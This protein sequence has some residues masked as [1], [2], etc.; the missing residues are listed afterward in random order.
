MNIG[1]E[2]YRMDAVGKE[3][4]HPQLMLWSPNLEDM[5]F[6]SMEAFGDMVFE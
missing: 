2:A 1:R 3:K 4:F 6:H 5:G